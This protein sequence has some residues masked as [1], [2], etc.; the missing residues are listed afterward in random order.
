MKRLNLEEK[1]L[2]TWIMNF[3]IQ[4]HYWM[5]ILIIVKIKVNVNSIN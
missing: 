4:K 1:V 3:N 5:N 2:F